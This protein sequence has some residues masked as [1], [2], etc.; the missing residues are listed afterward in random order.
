MSLHRRLRTMLLSSRAEWL[1]VPWLGYF[2]LVIGSNG[3][4][5]FC[6]LRCYGQYHFFVSCWGHERRS[7]ADLM[8]LG[9]HVIIFE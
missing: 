8:L 2:L 4:H 9:N 6:W 5:S 1:E 7:L 3:V